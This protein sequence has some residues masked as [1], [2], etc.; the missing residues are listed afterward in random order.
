M[1]PFFLFGICLPKP[2]LFLAIFYHCRPPPL[3]I[4]EGEQIQRNRKQ[5]WGHEVCTMFCSTK[6]RIERR[7]LNN[8]EVISFP[9]RNP[10]GKVEILKLEA[11]FIRRLLCGESIKASKPVYYDSL[12]GA[13]SPPS[14]DPPCEWDVP[15]GSIVCHT[16]G[17]HKQNSMRPLSGPTVKA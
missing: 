14:G 13:V 5:W 3:G 7:K 12:V 10:E 11:K 1:R 9:M 2:F 16:V 4:A 15:K 8:G 6:S 17:L